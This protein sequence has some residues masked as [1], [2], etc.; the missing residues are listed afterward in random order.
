MTFKRLLE[1]MIRTPNLDY[2]FLYLINSNECDFFVLQAQSRINLIWP[3]YA[4][5]RPGPELQP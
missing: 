2:P 1:A 4:Y 5:D 3:E